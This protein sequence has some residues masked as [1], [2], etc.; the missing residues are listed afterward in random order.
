MKRKNPEVPKTIDL[1]SD[2][3]NRFE[4]PEPK[5]IENEIEAIERFVASSISEVRNG[6]FG[7][8][9]E[10]Y[11]ELVSQGVS[12]DK[13]LSSLEERII[14]DFRS[15]TYTGVTNLR[16]HNMLSLL[17]TLI[18]MGSDSSRLLTAVENEV[19]TTLREFAKDQEDF[20]KKLPEVSKLRQGQPT[21][22]TAFDAKKVVKT[23][24]D[25]WVEL[26]IPRDKIEAAINN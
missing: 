7:K 2:G 5:P 19:L 22:A 11:G 26:G 6:V 15:L 3:G 25:S 1:K 8:M 4:M 10:S 24:I 9:K 12:K 18:E 16:L 17:E 23:M 21:E 14:K 20:A 13:L